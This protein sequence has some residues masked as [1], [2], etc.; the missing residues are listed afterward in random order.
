VWICAGADVIRTIAILYGASILSYAAQSAKLNAGTE[1]PTPISP[2]ELSR[3]V[4]H[5]ASYPDPLVARILAA[6]T[7]PLEV[8][9]ARQWLIAHHG[10]EREK[11][12]ALA[13]DQDWDPAVRALVVY[14]G[15]LHWM[16]RNL[17]WTVALGNA[18]L[19][20]PEDVLNA[21]QRARGKTRIARAPDRDWSCNWGP[22]PSIRTD[23]GTWT[24]NPD[25]RRGVPYWSVAVATRYGHA[26][27]DA[28]PHIVAAALAAS[29]GSA[30]RAIESGA[31]V[32]PPPRGARTD[33]RPAAF[34]LGG[35]RAPV[36]SQRG[37]ASF[38]GTTPAP[39]LPSSEQTSFSTPDD[40]ARELLRAA[41]AGDTAALRSMFLPAGLDL[42]TSGDPVRARDQRKAF[43]ERAK[44]R[45]AVET[46]PEAPDRATILIG[47]AGSPFA[48]PLLNTGGRWRF[49]TEA[50][51]Q[52]LRARRIGANELDAIALCRVY[53][54][55]Q[56]YYASIGRDG[57]SVSQYAQRFAGRRGKTDGLYS[58]SATEDPSDRIAELVKQARA[59]GH[60]P[61]D[62]SPVPYHGYFFRILSAQGP[63]A[64]GGPQKYLVHGLMIGGF[65]LLAW[66]ERYGASGVNAFVVNQSGRVYEKDLGPETEALAGGIETFDPDRTWRALE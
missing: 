43:V 45:M 44:K 2:S 27:P 60:D 17:K 14:P 31:R 3:L 58:D 40:A 29:H 47:P 63:N 28:T 13:A 18:F 7:Y 35:A 36:N 48:I 37:H 59:Q 66:P 4:A 39:A 1:D 22:H 56:N 54:E 49:D 8:V 23:S 62:G 52:E 57:S 33:P 25:H 19:A 26:R 38:P 50:G 6:S 42:L 21:I 32:G 20:Q 15:T 41:D 51:T 5:I 10:I 55:E 11:V 12:I 24:H 65:G 16:D 53:V 61:S 46:N 9:A 30:S 64:A 34:D